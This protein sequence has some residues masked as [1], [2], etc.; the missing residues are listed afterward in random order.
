MDEE[1]SNNDAEEVEIEYIEDEEP[2]T[3]QE[4]WE[5]MRRAQPKLEG[6]SKQQ[7]IKAFPHDFRLEY[8]CPVL[9]VRSPSAVECDLRLEEAQKIVAGCV[10]N[11][12]HQELFQISHFE[13]LVTT[14][15]PKGY[16]ARCTDIQKQ[17]SASIVRLTKIII[18]VVYGKPQSPPQ[19]VPMVENLAQS[20]TEC[21]F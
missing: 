9:F 3:V 5:N 8:R 7:A 18:I 14:V 21:G 13:F 15:T 1:D 10:N 11:T 19:V 2:L 4:I 16:H 6:N 20:M 17:W 12:L